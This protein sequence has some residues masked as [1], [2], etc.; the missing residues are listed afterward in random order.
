MGGPEG[1]LFYVD[2][3]EK[4]RAC[5]EALGLE[6]YGKRKVILGILSKIKEKN[7][8]ITSNTKKIHQ[9]FYELKRE[10][11]YLFQDFK[12]T[13]KFYFKYSPNL[14][15]TLDGMKTDVFQ[16]H[17]YSRHYSILPSK[18]DMKKELSGCFDMLEMKDL[19][20]IANEFYSKLG[21]AS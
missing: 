12:F 4:A 7:P 8:K 5:S 13:S 17:P 19:G 11:P 6:I 16:R 3:I 15:A 14:Q 1:G 10:Y 20:K 18:K 9:T 21:V 2:S